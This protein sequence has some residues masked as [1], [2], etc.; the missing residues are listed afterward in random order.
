M[1]IFKRFY[2][3]FFIDYKMKSSYN[4]LSTLC[5]K[6]IFDYYSNKKLK[7]NMEV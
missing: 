7:L 3:V 6:L 1:K 4:K 5:T 2:I